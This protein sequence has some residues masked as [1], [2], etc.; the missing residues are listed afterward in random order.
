MMNEPPVPI[1][2]P[3]EKKRKPLAFAG[4]LFDIALAVSAWYLAEHYLDPSKTFDYRPHAHT[5]GYA[6]VIGQ[7]VFLP[8]LILLRQLLGDEEELLKKLNANALLFPVHERF[9]IYSYTCFATAFVLPLFY[10]MQFKGY[11]G[12]DSFVYFFVVP[13]LSS[14]VAMILAFGT[15]ISGWLKTIF[16]K[17]PAR[18]MLLA[19]GFC[20]VEL[21]QLVLLIV[22]LKMSED[23]DSMAFSG[24]Y[25]LMG[26]LMGYVPARLMLFYATARRNL[27]FNIALASVLIVAWK[28]LF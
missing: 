13:L 19:A 6:L 9:A 10:Y 12:R 22:Q 8:L 17:R 7:A 5:I 18:W 3:E 4:N 20:Y 21:L 1:R 26:F 28:L 11:I 16:D 14:I 15:K 27:D 2:F 25:A 24:L 23:E